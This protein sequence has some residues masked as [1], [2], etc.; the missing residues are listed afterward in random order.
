[1]T[2]NF[3]EVSPYQ[4]TRPAMYCNELGIVC[5]TQ[6]YNRLLPLTDT[7]NSIVS[8]V[9]K[10]LPSVKYEMQQEKGKQNLKKQFG[11]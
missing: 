2:L 3:K 8:C 11:I 1:M 7:M 10:K 9:K 4:I 6:L 5:L